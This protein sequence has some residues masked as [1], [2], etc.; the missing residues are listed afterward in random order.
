MSGDGAPQGEL[1]GVE[2][3]AL[4]TRRRPRAAT[5]AVL[6]SL[7]ALG[8]L[9]AYD[10][11]VL[12]A[13]DPL[14][15]VW[16]WPLEPW[17]PTRL[18]W[19]LAV[20]LVVFGYLVVAPL[21]ARP[22]RSRRYWKRLREDTVATLAA[23]YVAAVFVVGLLGPVVGH[24]TLDVAASY[25][26]PAFTSADAAITANC[27]GPVVEG[28]C[29]GTLRYPFGTTF[30]GKGILA[31]TVAGTRVALAVALVAAMFIVPLATAVGTVS[32][33]VGG[34]VDDVLMRVVDVVQTVPPLF[35]YIVVR[36]VLG[37]GGDLVLLVAVFGLF[38]WGNVARVVRGEALA[39]RE[40]LFVTAAESAGAGPLYVV[41]THIVPNV[42][43]TVLTA[44]T[45]QIPT[46][47]LTEAALSYLQLG[48][49]HTASW[50][51]IIA[52]GARGSQFGQMLQTWWI[53][54]IPV[55]ALTLTVVALSIFGDA[56][57]DVLDPRFS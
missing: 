48:A 52:A 35:A 44:T 34:Q 42:S 9:Y 32:A 17:D 37:G 45:L 4:G 8:A 18:D 29:H 12:A 39:Q 22:D 49:P 31:Y 47:V 11:V 6:G 54:V 14:V 28:M 40:Q 5:I 3:G 51:T 19:L 41:R 50:G 23:G 13:N 2:E 26:P 33:Y 46:L 56:L 27:L 53:S 43:S 16:P 20:S 10:L 25:Q 55:V 15:D 7:A 36:F 1:H 38:S 21:L 57:R 24:P 30:G